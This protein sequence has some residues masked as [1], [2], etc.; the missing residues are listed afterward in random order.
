MIGF[1]KKFITQDG[2]DKYYN[3]TGYSLN[4][5]DKQHEKQKNKNYKVA[6]RKNS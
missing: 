6:E 4:S 5:G 3:K 2:Y 1:L